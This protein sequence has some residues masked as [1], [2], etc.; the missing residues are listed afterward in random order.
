M[1]QHTAPHQKF[2]SRV[3]L[4][5]TGVLVLLLA[6]LFLAGGL[7]V[8][9]VQMAWQ[10]HQI[11]R[12]I[13]HQQAQNAKQRERNRRLQGAAEFAESDVAA[14]QAARERLGMAREGETVLLPTVVLPPAPTVAPTATVPGEA[15]V[16]PAAQVETN[17]LRWFRALFPGPDAVP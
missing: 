6:L 2:I 17:A 10:E 8:G 1:A 14:E 15:P 4:Q 5:R 3:T 12:A 16:P 9:F 11:N 7:L 13:E